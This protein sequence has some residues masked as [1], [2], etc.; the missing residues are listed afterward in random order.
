MVG[1]KQINNGD[2]SAILNRSQAN[3]IFLQTA[4][5]NVMSTQGNKS[6]TMKI[7]FDLG[8][9][10]SYITPEA[11]VSLQLHSIGTFNISLKTFGNSNEEKQLEL[12]KFPV[13]TRDGYRV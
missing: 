5:A 7:L 8:S 1:S 11:R 12:V 13:L 9:Q 3:S 4:R 2:T 6:A 10:F